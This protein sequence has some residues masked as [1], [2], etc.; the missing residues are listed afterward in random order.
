MAEVIVQLSCQATFQRGP[1]QTR[2]HHDPRVISM[3]PASIL[4][5]GRLRYS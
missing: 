5:N 1:D 2:D 3:S 4:V